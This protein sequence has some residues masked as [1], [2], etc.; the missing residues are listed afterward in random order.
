MERERLKLKLELHRLGQKPE[1]F[2]ALTELALA[3]D[4]L[5]ELDTGD[6]E[7]ADRTAEVLDEAMRQIREQIRDRKAEA[8]A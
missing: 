6:M 8:A 7:R 3:V 4:L 1:G 5:D 2:L